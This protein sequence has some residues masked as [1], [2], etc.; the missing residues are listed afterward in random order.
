MPTEKKLMVIHSF[1]HNATHYKKG[2]ILTSELIEL[3]KLTPHLAQFR[4]NKWIE[5]VEDKPEK[6]SKK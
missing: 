3:A 1:I 2:A 6:T 4:K 5:D